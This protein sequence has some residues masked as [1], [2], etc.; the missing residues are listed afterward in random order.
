MAQIRAVTSLP[1]DQFRARFD[2]AFARSR[3]PRF[4]TSSWEGQTVHID[5]SGCRGFAVFD[6]GRIGGPIELSLAATFL[7]R[8]IFEE[9]ARVIADAGCVDVQ[10]G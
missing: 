4:V 10:V 3:A 1:F 7:R 2:E 6:G 9:I 5:G 8:Q